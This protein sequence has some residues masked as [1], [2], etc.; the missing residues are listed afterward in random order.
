MDI[1]IGAD[2]G[3]FELKEAC[4]AFLE[5]TGE[6]TVTDVGVFSSRS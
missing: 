3:G 6:Y 4:K 5:K 1:I 2:H